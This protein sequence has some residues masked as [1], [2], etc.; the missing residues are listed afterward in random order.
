MGTDRIVVTG[1]GI[2]TPIGNNLEDFS[3]AIFEGENGIGPITAF[4]VSHHDIQHGGEVKGFEP[5]YYF[6][7]LNHEDFDRSTQFAVATSKKALQMANIKHGFYDSRK[8]GCIF[9][10]TMGNQQIPEKY[11]DMLAGKKEEIKYQLR[12]FQPSAITSAVAAE[13]GLKGP[14]LVIPTACAAGNYAIGYGADLI[15]SKRA[16]CVICG[17][18]DAMSRVCYTMFS[19]LGAM[20]P[21]L[22]RPFDKD[23]HGMIVSEGAAAL[24][25]ESYEKAK[26]RNATIY[27]EILG[28]GNSCDAYHV[29]APHPEG[30]GAMLAINKAIASSGVNKSD[31]GYISAH[32]TGTKANDTAES[33]ALS[34]VFGDIISEIPISS[35]KSM[36]GHTMG[37]AAAIEAVASILVLNKGRLPINMNLEHLDPSIGLNVVNKSTIAEN[38]KY[39]LSNSFAFGGNISCIILGQEK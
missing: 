1:M 6:E 17:G 7:R 16:D 22:C 19:R 14:N 36:F 39:I 23:R 29:T 31:I 20:S 38:T 2:M 15:K 25:L 27:A 3:A 5:E 9:G 35:I 10:T 8:L 32:G 21:D 13:L 12:N 24:V 18:S 4:D 34:Q 30:Q 26:E 28:Y 11:N 33:Y 37:A